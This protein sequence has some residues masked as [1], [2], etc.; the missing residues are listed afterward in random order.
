MPNRIEDACLRACNECGMP[1]AR[2]ARAARSARTRAVAAQQIAAINPIALVLFP[3][4]DQNASRASYSLRFGLRRERS[5][6]NLTT[7]R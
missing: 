2:A 4:A 1:S 3:T 7:L 6:P 5:V